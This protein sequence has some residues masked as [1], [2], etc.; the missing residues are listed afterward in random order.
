[1][2]KDNWQWLPFID[3]EDLPLFVLEDLMSGRRIKV[4]T[5]ESFEQLRKEIRD[6]KAE[7]EEG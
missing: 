4:V 3:I 5:R 6:G 7:N 1:M 2:D